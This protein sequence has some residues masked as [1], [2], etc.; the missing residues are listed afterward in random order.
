MILGGSNKFDLNKK[1]LDVKDIN[2]IMAIKTNIDI[3]N[4]HL[5]YSLVF[6]A[7]NDL[8]RFKY[9]F[10]INLNFD[11][12]SDFKKKESIIEALVEANKLKELVYLVN[13]I[14]KNNGN[15]FKLNVIT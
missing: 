6:F 14:L 1:S 8:E 13:N 2:K 12:I 9:S 10:E 7:S 5:K 11:Y 3:K 4:A 15:Q